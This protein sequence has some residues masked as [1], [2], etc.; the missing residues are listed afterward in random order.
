M[1]VADRAVGE[2]RAGRT[3]ITPRALDRLV[4]T[5][6]AEAFGSDPKTT[7]VE[8]TDDGGQLTLAITTPVKVPSLARIADDA[9]LIARTG[10]TVLDRATSAQK[11]INE[12]VSALTGYSISRVS[13]RLTGADV[14]QE[15][16]VK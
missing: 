10:G 11:V 2:T 16:R 9:H 7:S 1:T 3:R 8:L 15:R 12:R 5:V 13:I 6:A 14:I 4:S